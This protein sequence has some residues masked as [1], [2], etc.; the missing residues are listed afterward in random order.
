[1]IFSDS[2]FEI[3]DQS[4][5]CYPN[6]HIWLLNVLEA[7]IYGLLVLST[8]LAVPVDYQLPFSPPPPPL[9]V[10]SMAAEVGAGDMLVVPPFWF[11]HV[12]TLEESVSVNV[13]SDAP[14]YALVNEMLVPSG[15]RYNPTLSSWHRERCTQFFDNLSV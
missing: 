13:W 10:Q 14:E 7:A 2:N 9:S 3:D 8:N 15:P 5:V 4:I 1:M 11:H 12:E 6:C